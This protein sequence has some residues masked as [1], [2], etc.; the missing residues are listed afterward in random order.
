MEI[1]RL[2]ADELKYELIIRNLPVGRTVEENRTTLRGAFRTEREGVIMDDFTSTLDTAEEI[3]VCEEKIR[4]LEEDI[5]HFNWCNKENEYKRITSRLLHI[6]L[7]LRRLPNLD[8]FKEART[9]L[10]ARCTFAMGKV[11]DMYEN[12]Q[13]NICGQPVSLIDLGDEVEGNLLDDQNPL[14]P[15]VITTDSSLPRHSSGTRMD[16]PDEIRYSD[17]TDCERNRNSQ[18]PVIPRIRNTFRPLAESSNIGITNRL[19]RHSSDYLPSNLRDL[20]VDPEVNQ[21][22]S[23][24]GYN[25]RFEEPPTYRCSLGRNLNYPSYP[26]ADHRIINEPTRNLSSLVRP[27]QLSPTKDQHSERC[28]PYLDVSRWRVQ[29][30]GQSSVNNFL[31]R[32]EELRRSRGVSKTRLLQSASELFTKDALI[33]YRTQHFQTWDDLESKLREDFQPYDY[34]F[35]L[36]EE[37]RRRTQGSKEKVVTYVAYGESL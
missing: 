27:I 26:E 9:T 19:S 18:P 28:D 13:A 35:D 30:D 10:L 20:N 31:E 4:H 7:R 34:S 15:Q 37:I 6:T 21:R 29:F 5:N 33:W 8:E 11:G 14:I 24:S 12:T 17:V 3:D 36:M 22:R 16:Q 1:N 32:V 2:L 25:V 23:S